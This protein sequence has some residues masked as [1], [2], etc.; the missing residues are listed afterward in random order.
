MERRFVISIAVGTFGW[1]AAISVV[2]MRT[3]ARD[4]PRRAATDSRLVIETLALEALNRGGDPFLST[5]KVPA[6]PK[7]MG[8]EILPLVDIF[9]YHLD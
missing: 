1:E 7:T 6:E 3:T 4:T 2:R 5:E 9:K 8:Q